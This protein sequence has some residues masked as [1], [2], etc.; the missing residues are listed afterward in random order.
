MTMRK[1][2]RRKLAPWWRVPTAII[3]EPLYFTGLDLDL[4]L[5]ELATIVDTGG[6]DGSEYVLHGRRAPRVQ[7]TRADGPRNGHP[8]SVQVPVSCGLAG[9]AAPA[10]GGAAERR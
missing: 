3:R 2:R 9:P 4:A 6:T 10:E 5:Q 8:L 1:F 7:P